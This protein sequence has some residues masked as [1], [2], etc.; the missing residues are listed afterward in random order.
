MSFVSRA[1][2]LGDVTTASLAWS[3]ERNRLV[4]I[5]YR[6]LGDFGAAEDIVSDVALEAL[7]AESSGDDVRSW[8][9]WL[10]T[11]CVRRS[12][13]QLR[14]VQSAREEYPGPWLPEP[15]AT[16]R[17]PDDVV[18]DREMLSLAVLHL[19][20]Q[21]E[22]AARAAVVLHR[23]FAMTS[24]EIARILDRSPASVRQLISRGEKRLQLRDEPSASGADVAAVRALVT[25]IETGD[26][27]GVAGI[28]TDDAI[29]WADGGGRVKSALNPIFGAERIVRFLVGILDKAAASGAAISVGVVDVN[30]ERGLSLSVGG[31]ADV[32]SLEMRGGL[33]AGV[34]RVSNPEKLSRVW[35][36]GGTSGSMSEPLPK[37]DA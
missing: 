37:L 30:G 7:R 16:E 14:R 20:E 31:M 24:V 5:A 22:P 35:W 12:I 32:I 6:M 9:A 2:S 13:D 11:V 28:L 4:G 27:A 33:I 1:G 3:T 17:L 15:V 25:A 36:T 21:L 8:A 23:A 26:V 10:T 34:R 19:A 29:L 18:A